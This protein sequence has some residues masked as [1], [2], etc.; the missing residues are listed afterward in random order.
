M[1]S[2]LPNFG[3]V[4][5]AMVTPYDENLELDLDGAQELANWL[6]AH[7]S[8]SI[9]VCG[10][11]GEGSIL[12]DGERE[13][14][15]KVVSSSV[16]IPVIAATGS[17]STDHSIELTK[18]AAKS[19]AA[20]ILLVT[21][22]YVRPSQQGLLDHFTQVARCTDLPVLLYDI[23]ARTGRRIELDTT[24]R[25]AGEVPN[26]IGLKDASGD[27]A[28]I[29]KLR[30]STEPDFMIYAGDDALCLAMVACGADGIISVASHWAGLEIQAMIGALRSGDVKKSSEFNWALTPSWEFES[31]ESAP[32]PIPTKAMLRMLSKPSGYCR[33]PLGRGPEGLDEEAQLILSQLHRTVEKL[34][35]KIVRDQ[36]K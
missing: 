6:A 32:N 24:I 12:S 15:L 17:G 3:T 30:G 2:E 20:G 7:G 22:Y 36:T 23:P 13:Q 29:S 14:L 16:S 10:S 31:M 35:L 18:M 27:V 21:P 25:L 34:G 11:T 19:G 4:V 1:T 9:V 5:T 28:G 8:D 26:I 33:A